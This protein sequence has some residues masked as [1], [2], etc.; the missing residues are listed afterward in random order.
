M[1]VDIPCPQCEPSIAVGSQVGLP[2]A[3]E[4]AQPHPDSAPGDA[5]VLGKGQGA[6]LA[7]KFAS[8]PVF[9]GEWIGLSR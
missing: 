7:H 9:T 3:V 8:D 6:L 4:T 5:Q 2:C 1:S